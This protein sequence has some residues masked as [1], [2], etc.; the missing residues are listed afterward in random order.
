MVVLGQ[1]AAR[2]EVLHAQRRV[3]SEIDTNFGD[4]LLLTRDSYDLNPPAAPD[5][6]DA[7]LAGCLRDGDSDGADSSGEGEEGPE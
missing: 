6:L 5:L 7:F 1:L 2:G 3:V 4:M